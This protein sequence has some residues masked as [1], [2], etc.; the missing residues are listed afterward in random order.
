MSIIPHVITLVARLIE[1]V[2][3]GELVLAILVLAQDLGQHAPTTT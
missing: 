3:A 1:L 2:A